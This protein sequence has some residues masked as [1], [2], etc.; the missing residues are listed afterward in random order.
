MLSRRNIRVK[1]MHLMYAKKLDKAISYEDL[2]KRFDRMV[3]QSYNLLL[4][5]LEQIVKTTFLSNADADRKAAK[6]IPSEA[7]KAFTPR[8]FENDLIQSLTENPSFQKTLKERSI[9]AR[10][11]AEMS[12][13]LYA[14]LAKTE[15]YQKYVLDA[16]PNHKEMLLTLYKEWSS[17]ESYEEYMEEK[18]DNWIHDKSLIVGAVK[19]IIKA[20]PAEQ[21]FFRD[22]Y[23]QGET[24]E[25]GKDLLYKVNHFESD[26]MDIIEPALKNWDANR[27]ATIDLI[28]LK[29]AL[30]EMLYFPSIPL[31]VTINEFVDISKIYSTPKSKDFIN[32]VLDRLMKKLLADGRIVK[33]GRGLVD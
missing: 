1:V 20:L 10:I 24:V 2:T 19:K 13:L 16:N 9:S 30:S 28:L 33:E 5:N 18:F 12:K 32:G 4:F 25:F 11:D 23:P 27:V 14:N 8:I 3:E 26:L 22:Y 6:H 21:Y 31:K 7:D 29:L 17:S 15:E